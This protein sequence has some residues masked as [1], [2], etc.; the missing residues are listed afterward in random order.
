MSNNKISF[1]RPFGPSIAKIKIPEEVIF[2]LNN[3]VD[4]IIIDE[5]K[6]STLDYGGKLAGNV[7]QE[8]TVKENLLRSSGLLKFLGKSVSQWIEASDK[9]KITHFTVNSSWIVRQFENEYNPI[10]QHSGHISGV[11][12]LKLPKDYGKPFQSTKKS[13]LNG[14]ICFI[15]GSKMFN[16]SSYINVEPK[17]GDFYLFPNYMMHTVYPFYGNE[18]RRSIS[19]NATINDE[20]Y[21]VYGG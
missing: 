15:H 7:K 21:N 20:I 12:Y 5:K 9:K 6:L 11:G 17:I 10:H 2:S 4:E 8:I 3:Y 16:S 18:E 19:F 14:N 13:N 1:I